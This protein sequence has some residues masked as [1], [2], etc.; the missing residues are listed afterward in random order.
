MGAL[1]CPGVPGQLVSNAGRAAAATGCLASQDTVSGRK[2]RGADDAP[3][4]AATHQQDSR[5][6][7]NKRRV[8]AGEAGAV[9]AEGPKPSAATR[10]GQRRI[11]ASAS[12]RWCCLAKRPVR[13]RAGGG[14]PGLPQDWGRRD[15]LRHARARER[16]RAT[17]QANG[18]RPAAQ[19]QPTPLPFFGPSATR[20]RRLPHARLV[21][22]PPGRCLRPRRRRRARR[23]RHRRCS[24]SAR[25]PPRA[26]SPPAPI[27]AGEERPILA[28]LGSRVPTSM[29][30]RWP[31]RAL[32]GRCRRPGGRAVSAPC[33]LVVSAATM[34]AT[35]QTWR[36]S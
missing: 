29:A 1:S 20:P 28:R 5:C 18:A 13:P 35:P 33:P 3:L 23:R 27:A 16:P 10:W 25:A 15:Q 21:R 30:L 17:R 2:T 11:E 32:H 26:P 14:G 22:A 36:S 12:C 24:S 8:E 4:L 7:K 31:A 34:A 9:G 19:G 6:P